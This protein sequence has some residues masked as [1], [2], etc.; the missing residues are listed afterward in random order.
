MNL[1]ATAYP[2]GLTA[3]EA[4]EIMK[5][6]GHTFGSA[7]G[8][9]RKMGSQLAGG[10]GSGMVKHSASKGQRIKSGQRRLKGLNK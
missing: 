6:A 5:A 7:Q 4:L 8:D 9:L 10:T 2:D 3:L 1:T